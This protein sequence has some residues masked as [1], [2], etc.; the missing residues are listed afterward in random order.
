MLHLLR[1][2]TPTR[3]V[4]VV[5]TL[6]AL[7]VGQGLRLCLH[8][9]DPTDARH[10][11]ATA[12]HLEGNLMSPGE[13]DD[14]ADQHVSLG[15]AVI[16]LVS[17]GVLAIFA[18]PSPFPAIPR[19]CRPPIS[20]CGH[21]CALHRFNPPSLSLNRRA[22]RVGA[23]DRCVMFRCAAVAAR[24]GFSGGFS[25]NDFHGCGGAGR[26]RVDSTNMGRGRGHVDA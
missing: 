18:N 14:G 16:K 23:R 5:V 4:A 26:C 22:R 21:R 12:A 11:H 6:L 3:Y 17:D 7:L 8:T 15:L 25:K 10:S 13:P 1:R 24:G 19:C 9:A 20:G 2:R